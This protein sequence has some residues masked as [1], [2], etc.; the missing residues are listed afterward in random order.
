MEP[1]VRKL[2]EIPLDTRNVKFCLHCKRPMY[3]TPV[4]TCSHCGAVRHLRCFTYK[5]DGIFYSECID[6]NLMTRGATKAESIA[7]LQ[8]E[9]FTYLDIALQDDRKDLIPRLSPL[10]NRLRYYCYL[11]LYRIKLLFNPHPPIA[12]TISRISE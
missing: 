4:L 7:R 9:A 10:P 2:R 11:L 3:R 5:S 1:P 6:L 8:E 12:T